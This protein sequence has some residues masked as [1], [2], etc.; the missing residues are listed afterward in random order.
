M[1]IFELDLRG[2]LSNFA[3]LLAFLL[4]QLELSFA[5]FIDFLLKWR[6]TGLDH[7][8]ALLN[9]RAQLILHF[10]QLRLVLPR[11]RILLAHEV[12]RFVND[13]AIVVIAY[14]ADKLVC[15][16]NLLLQLANLASLCHQ[17][18]V[19]KRDLR[20]KLGRVD[21]PASL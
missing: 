21:G 7:F 10:H 18:V 15:L 2:Q 19:E 1:L 5:H 11:Q 17:V 14:L 6:N 4:L 13:H 20:R 9:L 12:A 8:G 3:F 16:A